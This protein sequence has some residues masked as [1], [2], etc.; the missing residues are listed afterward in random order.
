MRMSGRSLHV[1]IISHWLFQTV[2]FMRQ[3]H[4]GDGRYENY[5]G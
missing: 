5:P 4:V 1:I 2:Q 3:S